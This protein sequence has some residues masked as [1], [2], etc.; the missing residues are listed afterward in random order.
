[1]FPFCL[2]RRWTK[3]RSGCGGMLQIHIYLST[4]HKIVFYFFMAKTASGPLTGT[5]YYFLLPYNYST[6][7][8]KSCFVNNRFCL[9]NV[10][11][12]YKIYVSLIIQIILIYS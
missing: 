12:V 11:K 9:Q 5:M 4:V 8:V 10:W 7:S 2:Q 6:S 3:L 1:M